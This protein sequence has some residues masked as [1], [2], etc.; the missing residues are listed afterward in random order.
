MLCGMPNLYT[1]YLRVW[2]IAIEMYTM[3]RDINDGD[4]IRI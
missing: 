2:S 1:C 3:Y 4:M